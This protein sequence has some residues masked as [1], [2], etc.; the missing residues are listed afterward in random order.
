MKK[1]KLLTDQERY[2]AKEYC[3]EKLLQNIVDGL[4][5]NDKE[6]EDNLQA[7]I[8]AALALDTNGLFAHERILQARYKPCE[9]HITEDD[10]LWPVKETL[11]SMA[12]STAESAFYPEDGEVIIKGVV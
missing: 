5:F 11:E 1:W 6:N 10:G 7:A 3:L 4:R 8:D 9:G 12:Y 2:K